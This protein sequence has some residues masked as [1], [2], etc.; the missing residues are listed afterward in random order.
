MIGLGV[1]VVL[2]ASLIVIFI[3]A[4]VLKW[5]NQSAGPAK[6]RDSVSGETETKDSKAA[7]LS[8]KTPMSPAQSEADIEKGSSF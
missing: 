6:R 3:V 4:I 1:G 5:K 2:T 7:L 8:T